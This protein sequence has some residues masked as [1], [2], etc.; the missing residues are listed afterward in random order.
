MFIVIFRNK[1]PILRT[2]QEVLSEAHL[3]SPD[4]LEIASGTGQHVA[5]FAANMPAATFQPTE[6]SDTLS[7]CADVSLSEEE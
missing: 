2:M 3:Q 5:H 4:I 1:E 7:R 6:Y